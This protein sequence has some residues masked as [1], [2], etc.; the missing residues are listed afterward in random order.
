MG[1]SSWHWSCAWLLFQTHA[2][3]YIVRCSDKMRRNYRTAMEDFEPSYSL[4]RSILCVVP[5]GLRQMICDRVGIADTSWTW[6]SAY[7]MCNKQDPN[8]I[9]YPARLPFSQRFSGA[10]WPSGDPV[11]TGGGRATEPIDDDRQVP[12]GS[13]QLAHRLRM[14]SAMKQL[15]LAKPQVVSRRARGIAGSCSRLRNMSADTDDQCGQA[16][17]CSNASSSARMGN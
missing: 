11:V 16:E 8:G 12:R 13:K 4:Y 9:D 7:M 3:I 15:F 17:R 1:S 10:Q 6:F 14:Q 2:L 5:D